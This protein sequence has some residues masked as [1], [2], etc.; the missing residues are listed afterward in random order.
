MKGMKAERQFVSIARGL[1]RGRKGAPKA[2][3]ESVF[4]GLVLDIAGPR[5]II[6]AFGSAR[7]E[8]KTMRRIVSVLMAALMLLGCVPGLGEEL[9]QEQLLSYYDGSVFVGDSITGQLRIYVLEQR[10]TKP[11]LL[12]NARF[13]VAQ[14]YLLYA[15]SR[16]F[17]LQGAS[18]LSFLGKEMA[19]CDIIG[20]IKPKRVLI[21]LGVNDYVGEK[22]EKGIGW[23][24]RIVDL[25]AETSPDTQVIFESLTPV[26]PKFCRKK[27]YRTMW[28]EYN[29]ALEEMC[30]RRGAG[31]IDIATPLKDAGHKKPRAA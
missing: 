24:E 5:D 29:A 3:R 23:C 11:E 9:T 27:D 16:K 15:A 22:I 28:D 13:L 19:L 20:Y 7:K 25:I 30:R 12:K 4:A 14:S 1:G 31:Y 10:V 17:T 2:G 8:G 26:T 21:L 6:N 18:N